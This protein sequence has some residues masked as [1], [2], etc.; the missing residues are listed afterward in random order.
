[1]PGLALSAKDIVTN[2]TSAETARI[3]G[4]GGSLPAKWES[5]IRI[6]GV[7]FVA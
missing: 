6:W 2:K 1:M 7:S 5:K 3:M 4:G